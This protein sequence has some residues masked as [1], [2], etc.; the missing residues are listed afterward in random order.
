MA[1]TEGDHTEAP[2]STDMLENE[3][4]DWNNGQNTEAPEEIETPEPSHY[5]LVLQI[6]EIPYE[7]SKAEYFDILDGHIGEMI[8]ESAGF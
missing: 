8:K 5:D 1:L 4:R 6:I 3:V 2:M 7:E